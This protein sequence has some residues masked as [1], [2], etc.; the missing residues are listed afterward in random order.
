VAPTVELRMAEPEPVTFLANL[1]A[2]RR[3]QEERWMLRVLDAPGAVAARGWPPHLAG[4]VEL[5]LEDPACPWNTGAWRLVLEEG[6]G[7]LEPGGRGSLRLDMRG[8]A[9]L[10]AGAASPAVLRRSG[11]LAG[12][13]D[14]DDAFLEAASAGPAPALLDPF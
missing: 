6:R 9:V 12:G 13:D 8:F 10:Y 5:A 14:G 3:E 7:R 4:E 2:A 11:L 1:T